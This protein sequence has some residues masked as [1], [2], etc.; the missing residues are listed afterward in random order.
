MTALAVHIMDKTIVK[1]NWKLKKI[2]F[3]LHIS[4]LY[5]KT[6]DEKLSVMDED[7]KATD[8]RLRQ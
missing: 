6:A 5:A 8:L 2:L 1:T 3:V 7:N 4:F